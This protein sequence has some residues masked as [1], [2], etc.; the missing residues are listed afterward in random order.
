[1]FPS[2]FTKLAKK[3]HTAR[4]CSLKKC[5]RA[6]ARRF[7]SNS[8]SRRYENKVVS[9]GIITVSYGNKVVSYE[10]IVVSYESSVVSYF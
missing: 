5:L 7:G 3:I 2:E 6:F 9:Y 8:H 4:T 10:I 1:M